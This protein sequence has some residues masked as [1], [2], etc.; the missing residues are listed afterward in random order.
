M[1]TLRPCRTVTIQAGEQ[2]VTAADPIPDEALHALT[3]L[4]ADTTH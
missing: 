3:R 2:T 1:K 4:R